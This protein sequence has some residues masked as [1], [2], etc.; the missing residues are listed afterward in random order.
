VS[1]IIPN[2]LLQKVMEEGMRVTRR[3]VLPL[4]AAAAATS[5]GHRVA[6]S[7]VIV[8]RTSRDAQYVFPDLQWET[9]SPVE[10]GWSI[11]GLA[12]T[13]RFFASLPS[14]S[15]V[16]VDRGRIVVAWGDSA[17]R[18]KLSSI[19]KSL[20]SA[21]YGR[22][23]RD[24]LIDLDTTL[25][26]LHIDDDPPLTQ[27]EKQATVRMLLQARSGVYHSYVG[28][29]PY[30]RAQMPARGSHPPGSFW[31][32]NNWD[33]N[34]LGGVYERKVG[35]KIGDAFEEEIAG[36]IKMQDFRV[37]DMYYLRSTD[38]SETFAK[39]LYPAYHFRLTAR[40]MARFG[41]LF[42]RHGNWNGMQII[43]PEWVTQSTTSYSETTGFGEGFGYGYL[44]WVR[45]Y[46]LDVGAISARGALGK[47]IIVIPERELVVAFVNHTEFPDGPDATST[48]EVKKL[49]DVPIPVISKLLAL[50]LACQS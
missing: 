22:P 2:Q 31:C 40:D 14:S 19:R 24:G 47:Y 15:L 41:Y 49:P 25:D 34:V 16:V 7:Q 20:L 23:V 26:S 11:Q 6:R 13:Y 28:G 48:A 18:V 21:L 4:A 43:P 33:F 9:A 29:T 36:P 8:P 38:S 32:Y 10:L 5:V 17:R 45:G 30:M 35:K 3:Q 27:N 50:L 42:L 44:W 46:G 39:S 12:E 37:D 1:G